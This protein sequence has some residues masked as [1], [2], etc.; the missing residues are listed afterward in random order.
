MILMLQ[1]YLADRSIIAGLQIG[2]DLI[3]QIISAAYSAGFK[4]AVF[5]VIGALSSFEI[6]F[7]DQGVQE[8]RRRE[9]QS[10]AE[11]VLCS[12]NLSVRDGKPFAHAHAAL[13][14]PDFS[15]IGGHLLSGKVFAAELFMTGLA[16]EPPV[17]S[18]DPVTGLFLWKGKG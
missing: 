12:G 9:V 10:P 6:A 7:Y 4:T 8:Y 17:R 13:A 2:E 15:V 11:I 16:G 14:L 5:S 3:E 1:E 18:H